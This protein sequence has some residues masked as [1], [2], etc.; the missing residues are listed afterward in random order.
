[1]TEAAKASG[2]SGSSGSSDSSGSE[3][4]GSSGG[5]WRTTVDEDV[6]EIVVAQRGRGDYD[7]DEFYTRA[8]NQHDHSVVLSVRVDPG[9]MAEIDSMISQRTIPHYKNRTDFIRDALVHR[10][11]YVMEKYE[12]LQTPEFQMM[13]ALEME[14]SR[15]EQARRSVQTVEKLIA[16]AKANV[17]DARAKGD[18]GWL[19]RT[20]ESLVRQLEW[21]PEPY[22][23]QIQQTVKEIDG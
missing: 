19:E 14:Q 17:A 16:D 13:L 7:P 10:L 2:S 12:D 22:R 4:S 11:H 3:S 15:V 21:V 23:S 1:M 18:A 20:R 9:V 5:R 8:V 6:I